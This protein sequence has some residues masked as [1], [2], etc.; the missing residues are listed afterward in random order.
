MPDCSAMQITI[1]GPLC[2]AALPQLVATILEESVGPDWDAP[3]G[4]AEEAISHIETTAAQG[5]PLVLMDANSPGGRA[6]DLEALCR[7]LD[8]T[9]HRCDDGHYAYP[10]E[11]IA[12]R[13][14]LAE[15]LAVHGTI[16]NGPCVALADLAE[17]PWQSVADVLRHYDVLVAPVPPLV[18]SEPADA[19]RPATSLEEVR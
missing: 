3:F 10:A 6:E 7:D 5:E 19:E 12:W 8:L 11:H 9:Y 2:R 13:P 14:G 4:N 15:P 1:G 17:G 18:L 16:D